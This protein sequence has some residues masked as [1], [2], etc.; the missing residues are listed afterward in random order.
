MKAA[1]LILTLLLVCFSG[2]PQAALAESTDDI[3]RNDTEFERVEPDPNA[4]RFA[5]SIGAV[6]SMPGG[7]WFDKTG[8]GV[9][10]GVDVL[11]RI[12]INWFVGLRLVNANIK[13]ERSELRRGG[14]WPESVI[15]PNVRRIA[16]TFRYESG[17]RSPND[18]KVRIAMYGGI[19]KV[20]YDD[21][22]ATYQMGDD[23][24]SRYVLGPADPKS[25]IMAH[26][27]TGLIIM[28][29][30]HLGLEAGVNVDTGSLT[31][32]LNSTEDPVFNPLKVGSVVN[33][34]LRL[35]TYFP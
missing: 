14:V 30:R 35:I 19:G 2:W 26:F 13:W 6:Y 22:L 9:G 27:G 7:E 15:E 11:V 16:A 5:V 20:L 29:Q 8:A 32:W 10:F 1:T 12:G 31:R 34:D 3:S 23:P 25:Q 21:G 17:F 18:P 24:G 33:L 28:L 4:R